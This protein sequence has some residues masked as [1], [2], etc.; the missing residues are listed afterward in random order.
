[1]SLP[2]ERRAAV[3]LDLDDKWTY[4]KTRGIAGW[5]SFP[6]YLEV[7]VPRVLQ[8]LNARSLRI[9]FFLVGQDAA[10]PRNAQLLRSIAVAGHEIGNHSFHHEPWLPLHSPAAIEDEIALAEQ[11]IAAVT[12]SSI[13]GFRGPGY[14]VS[15]SVIDALVSR[16]YLY[17]ASTL[18]TFLGPIARRY[19]LWTTKLDPRE[20]LLRAR[21][22]GTWRDG[23]RP[24]RPYPW[25]TAR[26][27]LTEIPV[28]TSPV[29]RTPFHLSYLIWLSRY[30][31]YLARAYF[32]SCLTLC[33]LLRVGPSFLL[34]PLDF[35]DASEA[36]ELAFFP[37]M[38][39]PL[40]RKLELADFALRALS[41]RYRITTLEEQARHSAA[42]PSRCQSTLGVGALQ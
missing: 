19:Y 25:Q 13:L 18:P 8:F 9:T 22:F 10:L 3:S 33:R 20:R 30:S 7:V 5:Q 35:L 31:E 23:L 36:Q 39:V 16:G 41:R 21:L 38:A 40:E 4:L 2:R 27:E 28:T 6:S 15:Q 34:H 32:L 1:M 26:G 42:D 29:F 17:D 24:L 14:S 37:G 12:D 11:H